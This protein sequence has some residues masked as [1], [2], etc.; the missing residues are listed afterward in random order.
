MVYIYDDI[1]GATFVAVFPGTE[2]SKHN[3]LPRT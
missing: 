1:Q 3:G 2:L